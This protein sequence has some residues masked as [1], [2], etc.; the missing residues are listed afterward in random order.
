MEKK[1]D[2]SANPSKSDKEP[3]NGNIDKVHNTPLQ[4]DKSP[5]SEKNDKLEE[6]GQQIQKT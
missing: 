6:K 5:K 4:S 3:E 2:L 1:E